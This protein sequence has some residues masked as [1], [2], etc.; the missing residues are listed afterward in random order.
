[1]PGVLCTGTFLVYLLYFPEKRN[2]RQTFAAFFGQMFMKTK[3]KKKKGPGIV[4]Q[5]KS[6]PAVIQLH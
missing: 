3:T 2:F 5:G 1:M 4:P 6:G